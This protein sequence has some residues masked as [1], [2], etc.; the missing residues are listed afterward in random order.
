[1]MIGLFYSGIARQ[2]TGLSGLKSFLD[3]AVSKP[4]IQRNLSKMVEE[5]EA[6]AISCEEQLKKNG[7]IELRK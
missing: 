1:M 3:S 6:K 4:H 5:G 2:T 7:E